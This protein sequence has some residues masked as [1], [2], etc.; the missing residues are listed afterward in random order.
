MSVLSRLPLLS[1]LLSGTALAAPVAA[2][3]A[4][5]VHGLLDPL[6]L[7]LADPA[8]V[9]NRCN[10][11]FA[12]ATKARTALE[13]RTG[14]AAIATDFAAY[15][16][17]ALILSDGSS[18][19]YL[20]SETNPDDK[21]RAAAEACVQK[22]AALV[23]DVSLSRPIYDRL[24]AISPKGLDTKTAY[25]LNKQLVSYR[26]AGVDKD[27][28]TRAKV[29]QLQKDIV[30]TGLLFAK[31]IRDDKGDIVLKPEELRGLPQDYIDTH[32]PGADGLVHISYD[33]PD[34]MPVNDFASIRDT[35]R[36]V[37][38]AFRNR[39]WPA[40]ETVLK[41]LLQKRHELATLLGMP[42]YATL[43]TADKMIG[44]PTRAAAFLDDVNAAAK[45]GAT[46]DYD[47]LFAF[48]KTVDPGIERLE[49]WDNAY[50]Q[51]LLRKQ[52]YAVDAEVV[53]Q[54]FTYDKA[55]QGIFKLVGDLFGAD[56]RPWNTPV[57]DKSVTAWELYD[58]GKLI[59]R[60][61]LDMHPRKGKFNHAA[62]F[63]IRTGVTG[64]QVPVGALICN[65]PATG[66]MDHDDVTTFL[67][68]F[69]HLIHSLYSGKQTYSLQ[70]MGNLQ[71]DF[72]EAPS[73]LLEEWTWDYD[74]LK[75]FA[76]NAQGQP[77]P[78]DLVKK[79]NAGRQFGEA[80]RWKGQLAYSAVSLNFYNRAPDFDLA[81]M[82]DTQISR[83]S[84]FP[85]V[86]NTH[87]YASFGHLDGYS[88]IYY[89]YVWS[90]A[91]ALDLFTRFKKDGIR[92]KATAMQYRKQVLEPGGS[93]DANAL[94]QNFLGRP[95]SLD[96]FKDELAGK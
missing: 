33:Y 55:R 74:T 84:M 62:Q 87:S 88:A 45:P 42:D 54:Y 9:E 81:T 6:P 90:K 95:L 53:R 3:T 8:A 5:D 48:A 23:T 29:T 47:E 60:F 10:A 20:I 40:N 22:L 46:K 70:S 26:L 21:I 52:K 63:P 51:N 58:Q 78:E 14:T 2:P 68:E 67:H 75:G 61:Y 86:P 79:M 57:W 25:A 83:Y 12:L 91:I 13:A 7:M 24:S 35:R 34:I 50:M 18:E 4:A 44:N 93:V 80:V 82:Y 30:Q 94:I 89:T 36:K 31:N 49:G 43:I 76:S 19:M 85:V 64:Q 56:I 69:G 59:G 65:F 41:T 16:R 72:I 15:D 37:S 28:A 73:Q 27:A 17:L 77:I 96:A 32:K 1:L 92:D 66:P 71:W 11:T 39:G 38:I